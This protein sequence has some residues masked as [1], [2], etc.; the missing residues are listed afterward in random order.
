M[1][2]SVLW[3]GSILYLMKLLIYK[4]IVKNILTHGA[5]T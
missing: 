5:V 3:N 1:I 4:S 2:N